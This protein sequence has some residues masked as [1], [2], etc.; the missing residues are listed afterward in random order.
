M[1]QRSE[2]ADALERMVDSHARLIANVL[3]SAIS[4]L[5]EFNSRTASTKSSIIARCSSFKVDNRHLRS[6]WNHLQLAEIARE[7]EYDVE[8]LRCANALP[9]P[10]IPEGSKS[11]YLRW[12]S[13]DDSVI[14]D[15]HCYMSP[16][17]EIQG[18]SRLLAPKTLTLLQAATF[19]SNV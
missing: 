17:F 9:R 8:L 16:T 6:L 12:S 1:P 4:S 5:P 10:N 19:D 13:S 11:I 18:Y 7:A 3:K 14:F 15:T 2:D